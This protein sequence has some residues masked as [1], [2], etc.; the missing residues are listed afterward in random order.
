[1]A[2]IDVQFS[3]F[4]KRDCQIINLHFHEISV[5]FGYFEKDI[6]QI[7]QSRFKNSEQFILTPAPFS[8]SK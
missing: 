2:F 6:L 3:L 4:P 1:M 5:P 8:Y 7:G